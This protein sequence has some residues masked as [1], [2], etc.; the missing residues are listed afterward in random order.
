MLVKLGDEFGGIFADALNGDWEEVGKGLQR[1]AKI[2][3]D[4]F[5]SIFFEFGVQIGKGLISQ[6]ERLPFFNVLITDEK[7]QL[8]FGD[9]YKYLPVNAG[10]LGP[11]VVNFIMEKAIQNNNNNVNV[12]ATDANEAGGSVVRALNAKG[13]NYN[14]PRDWGWA[15]EVWVNAGVNK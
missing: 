13:K 4:T 2:F 10:G 8:Q 14:I 11:R 15:W 7:G 1:A 9:I 5:L 3:S 12:N 6:L